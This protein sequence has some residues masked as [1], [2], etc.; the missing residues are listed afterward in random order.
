M[1]HGSEIADL[2]KIDVVY[3][4]I[5]HVTSFALGSIDEISLYILSEV[6]HRVLC[7]SAIFS[8]V[9]HTITDTRSRLSSEKVESVELIRWGFRAGLMMTDCTAVYDWLIVVRC[10]GF[11]LGMGWVGSGSMI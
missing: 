3:I 1:G 11:G 4:I 7:I 10:I 8:C 6:A 9:G 2:R 5:M